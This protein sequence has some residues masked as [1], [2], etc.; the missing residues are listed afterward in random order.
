MKRLQ[1]EHRVLCP[2]CGKA[3]I[4][5]TGELALTTGRCG[6]CG[7]RIVTD[8]AAEPSKMTMELGDSPLWDHEFDR[9]SL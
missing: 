7:D 1:Q 9:P 8:D 3:L 2:R 6:G 5:L 4:G